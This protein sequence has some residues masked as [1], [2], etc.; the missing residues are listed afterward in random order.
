MD[1]LLA[2]VSGKKTYLVAVV[3]IAAVG[4]QTFGVAIPEQV[5]TALGFLGLGTLRA[6]VADI[7]KAQ[8]P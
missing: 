4:L 3:A 1:K 6:A 5:W 8:K 7:A 2:L